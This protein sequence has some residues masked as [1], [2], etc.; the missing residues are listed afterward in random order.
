MNV[1]YVP[2]PKHKNCIAEK[3]N[4]NMQAGTCGIIFGIYSGNIFQFWYLIIKKKMKPLKTRLLFLINKV[5]V[6]D[7]LAL[8][9]QKINNLNTLFM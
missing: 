9:E 2:V 4:L 8:A 3:K 7:G 6:I 5:M 1:E